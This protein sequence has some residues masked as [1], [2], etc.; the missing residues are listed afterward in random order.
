MKGSSTF[1]AQPL[2]TNCHRTKL[3]SWQNIALP[4]NSKLKSTS[5]VIT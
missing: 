5:D 2:K 1:Y 3:Q 4:T